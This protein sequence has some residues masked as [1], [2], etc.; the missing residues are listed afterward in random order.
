MSCDHYSFPRNGTT[1]SGRKQKYVFHSSPY[2]KQSGNEYLTPTQRAQKHIKKLRELLAQARLDLEQ[3]DS[4]VIHLTKEVV[5][6][7]LF[8]ASLSSPEDKSNSSEAITVK[9]NAN[10]SN[11]AS[12]IVDMVVKSNYDTNSPNTYCT[13]IDKLCLSEM[14]SSFADSGHFEDTTSSVHSKDLCVS[15]RE[16]GTSVDCLID[17]DRQALIEM[18]ERKIEELIKLH[19]TERQEISAKHNDKIE[20]LLQKL[21]ECNSRY[22]NIVPDYEEVCFFY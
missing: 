4:E 7:R 15:T 19:D 18:Y 20:I 22:S 21:A 17:E 12:P 16:Q 3:K 1:F 6:L 11:D 9:E 5:E 10:S 8:K 2:A 13:M 14:H